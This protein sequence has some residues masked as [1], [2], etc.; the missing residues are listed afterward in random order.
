MAVF[1]IGQRVRIKWSNHW[2]ELAGQE[3]TVQNSSFVGADEH[4]Q[5]AGY[6]YW[7][8]PDCWGTFKAPDGGGLFAPR[9]EQLEPVQ[10]DKQRQRV[11]EETVPWDEADFNREG[12]YI[13]EPETIERE[14]T[15]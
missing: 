4:V 5:G 6:Y 11:N 8:A 9:G 2:P 13:G 12:K 14:V 3:G 10:D 7:V 1:V 15:A